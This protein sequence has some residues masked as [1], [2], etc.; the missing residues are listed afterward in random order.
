MLFRSGLEPVSP[1]LA[2]RF[3]TTAPP[4]KP[5]PPVFNHSTLA[6]LLLLSNTRHTPTLC[7][8]CFSCFL[9]TVL[10]PLEFKFYGGRDFCVFG[11]RC[12]PNTSPTRR[13][14]PAYVTVHL[15]PDT[16]PTRRVRPAYVTVHL[17]PDTS[18]TY[19]IP[20]PPPHTPH[21]SIPSPHTSLS[22][23]LQIGRAHV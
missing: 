13:V 22:F 5:P 12:I 23:Y 11:H 10:Y 9:Y 17:H 7:R 8:T 18:P 3:S 19:L 16:S 15:H 2:G 14:R 20:L 6:F 21:P 4:G 1:A